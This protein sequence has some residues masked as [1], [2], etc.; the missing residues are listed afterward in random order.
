[1]FAVQRKMKEEQLAKLQATHDEEALELAVL[2]EDEELPLKLLGAE[3]RYISSRAHCMMIDILILGWCCMAA[4]GALDRPPIQVSDVSFGYPGTPSHSEES[5]SVDHT[6]RILRADPTWIHLRFCLF[7]AR[8]Q[9]H[10]HRHVWIVVWVGM[11]QPLFEHAEICVNGKQRLVL[12]G[13]N[14]RGKTTLVKL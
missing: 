13:E 8:T 14:G 6:N 2:Q 5:A 1:M 7:I 4:G 10:G 9:L 12:L 11:A 3:L